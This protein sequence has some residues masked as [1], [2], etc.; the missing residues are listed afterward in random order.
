MHPWP[1][2]ITVIEQI[3]FNVLF[4][5]HQISTYTSW[6]LTCDRKILKTVSTIP[7]R[8]FPWTTTGDLV[9]QNSVLSNRF[10]KQK[11]PTQ[12]CMPSV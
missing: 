11:K 8:E 5:I 9:Q 1:T 2:L 4:I 10:T 6:Q 12:H 3:I 7:F